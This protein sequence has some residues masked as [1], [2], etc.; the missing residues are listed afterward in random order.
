MVRELWA[1]GV[2]VDVGSRVILDK[3]NICKELTRMR[4]ETPLQA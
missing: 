3:V 1:Q 2:G 4:R